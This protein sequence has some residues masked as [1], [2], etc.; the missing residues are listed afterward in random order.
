MCSKCA[1]HQ[2]HAAPCL[3]ANAHN[4]HMHTCARYYHPRNITISIVGD[5]EPGRVQELAAR[6]FG[7]WSAAPG[8]VTLSSGQA[9]LEDRKSVV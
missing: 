4:P 8:A 1:E 5:V 3:F 7:G 9:R 2:A 6:Y